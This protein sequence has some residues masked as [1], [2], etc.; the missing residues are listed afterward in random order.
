MQNIIELFFLALAS[1]FFLVWMVKILTVKFRWVSVPQ[2]N[3]WNSRT[4]S[5][6][7]GVGFFPVIALGFV[8]LIF[9]SHSESISV[10]TK[11]PWQLNILI[12]ILLGSTIMFILGFVDDIF[13]CNPIVKVLVQAISVA[14]FVYNGGGFLVFESVLL[15]TLVTFFWF[16]IV[17]NAVNLMD[18]MDGLASGIVVISL[19]FMIF[20]SALGMDD[21]FPLSVYMGVIVIASLLAFL[22]FNW[23]PATIFM[24]DSGSL[25]IGFILASLLIPSP[26]NHYLGIVQGENLLTI[27]VLFLTPS[28]II[29]VLL[30]DVMFVTITRF[31]DG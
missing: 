19:I 25:S 20:S 10:V 29:I 18:N 21:V 1:S 9:Q 8:F 12:S 30:F 3:R 13:N 2:V 11:D 14:I 23:M 28:L 5:L 22:L 7:G 6:H 24:G 15:N 26:I 17:I 16:I 4:V 31:F 27:F